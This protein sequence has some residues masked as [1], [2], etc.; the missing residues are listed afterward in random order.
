MTG[1]FDKVLSDQISSDDALSNNEE[2]LG[3]MFCESDLKQ[4][5]HSA[6][7]DDSGSKDNANGTML[8][9]PESRS[10]LGDEANDM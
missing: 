6:M 2:P 5:D 10:L 3:D 8:P 4:T 7:E 9:E 1:G